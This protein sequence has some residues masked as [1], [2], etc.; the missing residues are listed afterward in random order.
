M[1]SLDAV[2]VQQ[3]MLRYADAIDADDIE[4]W[5]DFFT[6]DGEYTVISRESVKRGHRIG[7]MQCLG[8]G[9][10]RDRIMGLRDANV[11]EPHCYRHVVSAPLL[12][13]A[14]PDGVPA[15]ASFLL[16]RTMRAGVPELFLSGRYEDLVVP[17]PAGLRFRRRRVVLDS[18]AIDTLLVIPV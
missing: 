9:M 14:G 15:T 6:P 3:L 11:Y 2:E 13:E 8:Q 10:M 7:I 17:T 16:A 4:A 5:P 18:T 1:M 12:G